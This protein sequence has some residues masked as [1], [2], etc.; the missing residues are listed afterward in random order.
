MRFG[1]VMLGHNGSLRTSQLARCV[2]M[3]L[4]AFAALAAVLLLVPQCTGDNDSDFEGVRFHVARGVDCVLLPVVMQARQ[5]LFLVDTG[6]AFTVVDKSLQGALGDCLGHETLAGATGAKRAEM[7]GAPSATLAGR[8]LWGVSKVVCADL[9]NARAASG[10]EIYGV[11]GLDFLRHR[12]IRIDFDAGELEF[13]ASVPSDAGKAVPIVFSEHCLPTVRFS[14]EGVSDRMFTIDTGDVEWNAG[15][16]EQRLLARLFDI[17]VATDYGTSRSTSFADK[18]VTAPSARLAET[19]L[20]GFRHCGL[21]FARSGGFNRLGIGYLSR[22][23]IVFDFPAQQMYL[24]AGARFDEPWRPDLSGLDMS[25][26]DGKKIVDCVDE[27]S[28]AQRAGLK[29]GDV[30]EEIDS[31]SAGTMSIFK[32]VDILCFPGKHSLSLK[33][34]NERLEAVL[35][36]EDGATGSANPPPGRGGSEFRRERSETVQKAGDTK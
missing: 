22:F 7:F 2:G 34:G 25:H 31:R 36:L 24:K 16:V 12:I 20:A 1:L 28:A 23:A 27:G 10:C 8:P 6:S 3:A 21:V 4:R 33:R 29:C 26:T 9:S 32:I 30:I 35:V 15:S 5:Y 17:G 14:I 18:W 11:L 13:L 19:E